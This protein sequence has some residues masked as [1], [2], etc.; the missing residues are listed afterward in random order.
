[1]K[2]LAFVLAMVFVTGV[3][4]GQQVVNGVYQGSPSSFMYLPTTPPTGGWENSWVKPSYE[5]SG[6]GSTFN[7]T[8]HMGAD[9]GNNFSHRFIIRGADSTVS[10]TNDYCFRGQLGSN[11]FNKPI[12]AEAWN[13]DLYPGTYVDT[14]IQMG[15]VGPNGQ[16]PSGCYAQQIIY[17]FVPDT[18]NPVLLLNFAFVTEDGQHSYTS[19]P[20]V[21]F[22]VLNHSNNY[23][24]NNSYLPL[25]NYDATHP[26]SRFWY[27]TPSNA[28]HSPE[29]PDNTPVNSAPEYIAVHG[30]CPIQNSG[31]PVVTY[32]YTIVAY[33]LS[34]QA[35]DHTAVDFRIRVNSCTSRFHWAYCYFT[36]K[37]IPAKL[38]V[39][40]CGGDE[41]NLHVPWG[42]D[43]TNSYQWYNGTDAEHANEWF[44]PDD[45]SSSGVLQGSTKYNP[46]LHANPA[47]PYYRCVVHSYTGIPFTYQA[48]VNY[49]DLQPAFTVEPK[50]LTDGK[51]CDLGVVVHNHSRIGVIRPDGQGGVDTT[52]Q[53]LE[54]HPNQ[55]T[56]D[57]GDG[58]PE[59]H[60]FEPQHVY[61][62]PGTYTIKLHITDYDNICTSPD[63]S[64]E[65]TVLQ[66]YME[67]Q[68]ATDEATT[69]E[70]KLPYYYKP[71]LFGY[72]NVQTKW[73][74]N[75][76]GE[77]TVNY[78]YAL[79]QYDIRAWN[80]CDS[81]VKVQ[82]DVLT[83]AVTIQEAG[84]DFCDSAQTTLEALVS[85]VREDAV[86]YEWT[87]MDS[88][89]SRTN[90]M[91]A[92]SDGTYSVSIV[93][94]TTGCEAATSYKIDP[95]V[96][97]IF[98]PNCITPTRSTNEGPAQNDYFYLDQFVQR[99][100]SEVKF[101]VYARNGE[102]VY[103]YEGVKNALGQFEPEPPFGNLPAEM[104]GRLVLWDGTVKGRIV[105]G[106]YTYALWIVSGGQSYLY[107]GK[108]IVM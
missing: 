73:D 50:A 33:D 91:L 75:A 37:M 79:P 27:R 40:Y 72:D 105:D 2:R 80:G 104:N 38:H 4:M 28:S 58:T 47:K 57:F 99:F 90:T 56:W 76:V 103:A 64:Q 54:N 3:A 13:S 108:L 1:M 95:C 53:D 65:V 86:E 88:V 84:T 46:V 63:T 7:F 31:R 22:A 43:E 6:S 69:C 39:E 18:M 87:Y 97:N 49:Y 24:T 60:G 85:N 20:A 89:M 98:L 21:E 67:K 11:F 35:R 107:K 70:G 102:Q 9:L 96:P 32:P 68:Y 34:Q 41:L 77:R 61:A 8:N 51:N 55:C 25:G 48:T 15:K 23:S 78:S 45:P 66:E 26:Y 12:L 81:I 10:P 93:D 62:Q 74:L 52:W 106:T 59:V 100:I 92:M 30:N 29:D 44:D 82:F 101:M 36:A 5:G 14:V 17:S 42:F 71:E 94:A 83:P 16:N 19:N